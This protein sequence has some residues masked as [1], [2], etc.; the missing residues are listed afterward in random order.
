MIF[1]SEQQ[2]LPN[3]KPLSRKSRKKGKQSDG[4]KAIVALFL[5]TVL[6]SALF[7][8]Q[9]EIPKVWEEITAPRVIFNLPEK[10]F[11]PESVLVQIK[12]LTRGLSGTYGVYVYRLDSKESY[13]I[14]KDEVFPAASLNKLP[15]MVTAYQQAE[16]GKIDLTTEYTLQE[17][18]KIGGAGILQSK[19][20]GTK[21]TYRQLI[22]YM[23]QYSDNIAFKIMRRVVGEDIV[24][25]MTP[26]EMGT[27][28]K[29]LY[30]GELISQEYQKELLQFLTKTTF[31]D[32]IPQ[33]VP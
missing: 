19:P 25:Q 24:N 9:A 6:A 5:I 28:L 8:L 4:R 23:A 33:G 22:E 20:V 14:N 17:T 27:L 30:Q 11:N 1:E 29:K 3:I 31:E 21:Y 15:V 13:G 18:D 12:S 26:E 7:Y 10:P 16:Q 2:H 32:R